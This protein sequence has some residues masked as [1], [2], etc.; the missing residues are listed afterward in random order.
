MGSSAGGHLVAM[1][2]TTGASDSLGLRAPSTSM[3]TRP[4]AVV[5]YCPVT[6]LTDH[7]LQSGRLTA[8]YVNLIDG[9]ESE[10]PGIYRNASPLHR[11][12]GEEPPFLFVHGDADATVPVEQSEAMAQRLTEAGVRAELQVLPGVEHGFGYGTTTEP[13]RKSLALVERFLEGVFETPGE[14]TL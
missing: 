9:T 10:H 3:D 11:V 2:A 14:S 6:T 1:L 4:D 8:P 13:Q 5:C 12:T 7:K